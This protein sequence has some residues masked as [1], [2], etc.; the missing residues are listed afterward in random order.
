ML[1]G[2]QLKELRA[3]TLYPIYVVRATIWSYVVL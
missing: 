3:Y 1:V 2:T